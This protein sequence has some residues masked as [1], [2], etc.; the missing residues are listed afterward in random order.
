MDVTKERFESGEVGFA[1]WRARISLKRGIPT[2]AVAN[3]TVVGGGGF[4]SHEVYGLDAVTGG[5]KWRL[6]TR[7]DG[8]TAAVLVDGFALFNTESC[9][10]MAVD[11]ASGTMQWEKWL[12]D[13]LLAQPAAAD[14]RVLMVFPRKG[15][16]WLGAF[17]LRTGD[18]QWK[19]G[20][21]MM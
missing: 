1:G 7:D 20:L 2:P 15:S 5:R 19:R 11:M 18:S 10:L 16:H 17:D 3:G 4:G 21:D 12:G 13:P 8:P 9:T 14:G 6:R